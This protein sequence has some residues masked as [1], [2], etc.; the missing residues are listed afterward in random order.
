MIY[1][2]FDVSEGTVSSSFQKQKTETCE[3]VKNLKAVANSIRTH[4]T[5]TAEATAAATVCE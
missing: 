3:K 5:V 1:L 2:T 4:A